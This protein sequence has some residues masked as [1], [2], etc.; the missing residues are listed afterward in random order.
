[1]RQMVTEALLTF[2]EAGRYLE[3]SRQWTHQLAKK[4]RLTVVRLNGRN[5]VTL[6]SVKHFEADMLPS[7]PNLV[8]NA[9]ES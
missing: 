4:G 8:R 5:Y 2:A 6:R 7:L 1:M 9:L 3:C